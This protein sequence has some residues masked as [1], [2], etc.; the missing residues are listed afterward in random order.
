[1]NPTVLPPP[2]SKH[3]QQ[4]LLPRLPEG[5]AVEPALAS[6]PPLLRR[7]PTQPGVRYPAIDPG[8]ARVDPRRPQL[9]HVGWT[10]PSGGVKQCWPRVARIAGQ[11]DRP[12]SHRHVLAHCMALVAIH[13]PLAQIQVDDI[14]RLVPV[15]K[16]VKPPVEVDALLADGRAGE[17]EGPER[18]VERGLGV[19]RQT[20]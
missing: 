2:P 16:R 13:P 19:A 4:V 10:I 18:R 5:E 9:V 11:S 1:M 14:G 8:L 20:G 7:V 6:K 12:V 17:Q 3:L 15:H